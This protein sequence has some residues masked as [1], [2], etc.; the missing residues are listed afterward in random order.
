[1]VYP[2]ADRF[3][4]GSNPQADLHGLELRGSFGCSGSCQDWHYNI[5]GPPVVPFYTFLGEASPTKIDR[6]Q[7][8]LILASLLEDLVYQFAEAGNYIL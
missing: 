4:L 2:C 1:M 6:K 5:P 7:G 8:T 3:G